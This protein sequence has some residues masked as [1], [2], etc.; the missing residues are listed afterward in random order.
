MRG[1]GAGLRQQP[2]ELGADRLEVHRQ[3]Q[4]AGRAL[5]PRQMLLERERNAVVDAEHL[6]RPVAADQ[7]LVGN[8]DR[9]LADGHDLAVD[10]CQRLGRAHAA[11]DS[12][13]STERRDQTSASRTIV[14][15]AAAI[16]WTDAHSRTE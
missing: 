2:V 9:R 16:S 14:A 3:P 6:E 8:R 13:E 11:T 7:T 1:T 5:E 15:A 4:V 10:R 12:A